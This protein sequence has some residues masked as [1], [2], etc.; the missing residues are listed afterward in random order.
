MHRTHRTYL[1]ILAMLVG[2]L[3]AAPAVR[4]DI[5]ACP[6]DLTGGQ[7]TMAMLK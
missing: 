6:P 7:V 4:A 3:V 1:A 2:V 5:I